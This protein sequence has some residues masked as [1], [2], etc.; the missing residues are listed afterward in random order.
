VGHFAR[1]TFCK[2]PDKPAV[3]DAFDETHGRLVRRRAFVSDDPVLIA[4]LSG[5]RELQQV[6]AVETITGITNARS[7]GSG[8]T[9]SDIRYFLTSSKA[10]GLALA[11]AV[12]D[13]WGIENSLHWVLDVG[14]REDESRLRDR[15]AAANLAVIGLVSERCR[16]G[17]QLHAETRGIMIFVRLP[18]G[19]TDINF[20]ILAIVTR[21]F[22]VPL[23]LS[24][25]DDSGNSST[26]QHK[27]LIRR[28]LRV[29][30]SSSIE[31]LLADREFIG[32]EWLD[33]LSENNVP[34]VVRLRENMHIHTE[35]GRRLQLRS[36]LR[37]RRKGHCK[38]WLVGM[39]HAPKNLVRFQ[40]KRIKG[41]ELLLVATNIDAPKNPLNLYRK[42][43]G[44]ECL[45]ADAK[46]RGFN[47]EDTHITDPEQQRAFI[48]WHEA[49]MTSL[50]ADEA[51][52]FSDAVHPEY[53]SRAAHG[54]FPRGQKTALKTTSGRKRLNIQG[55]LDL[56]T[57]RF[58]FVEGER[59]NAETTRQMLEKVE[60]NYPAL[61]AIHV[62]LDNARYH[63]AKALKPWLESSQRCVKLHFLPSTPL[64]STR[65]RGFGAS[66]M[67]GL[68]TTGITRPL[69]RSQTLFSAFFRKTLPENRTRFRDTVTDNFR[70]ISTENCRLI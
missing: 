44:I 4:E 61:T 69:T 50:P 21:R 35:D 6:I 11:S 28:Y 68:R 57:F 41:G 43:W 14:F 60:R 62:I 25:L 5:W 9:K 15:N 17:Q 24:L 55:A 58:T 67:R 19:K 65:L 45:F 70:V 33:F 20:L 37:K 59:I 48:D 26:R 12:R 42:R 8:K 63:H 66:C 1:T 34:F 38:G 39:R 52:L 13:H 22:K 23:M 47:I 2:A 40:G 51:V 64:T 56:E 27:T 36:L 29:F 10:D 46:T 3:Y 32:G 7:G 30:G 54:W 18:W 31:A 53:Q 49:L 16:V